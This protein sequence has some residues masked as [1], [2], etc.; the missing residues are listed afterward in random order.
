M[1]KYNNLHSHTI[2][3]DGKI[4]VAETMNFCK[5]NGVSAVAFTDHDTLLKDEDVRYL[6]SNSG[7]VKWVSGVELSI[8]GLKDLDEGFSLFHMVGLFVDPTNSKLRE[9]CNTAQSGR[10]E[11]MVKIVKNLKKIDITITEDDCLKA[12]GGETVG[13][14][15]IVEAIMKYPENITVMKNL[16]EKIKKDSD[17]DVRAKQVVESIKTYG[18]AQMPYA[19]FLSKEAYIPDIY[20]DYLFK[21]DFDQCVKVIRDAGGLSFLAHYFTCAHKLPFS[22]L[23]K[24]IREDRLDGI[25]IIYGI[26]GYSSDDKNIVKSLVEQREGLTNLANKTGCLVSGGADSHTLDDWKSFVNNKEYAKSTVGLLDDILKNSKKELG[27]YLL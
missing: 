22:L 24:I 6:K 10:K 12:S 20:V 11:R 25:E 23:E 4:T 7:D 3:S 14:P 19:I 15:H 8:S 27:W 26:E 18:E 21:P 13:R 16:Y 5:K 2:N 17:K 1:S 9:F